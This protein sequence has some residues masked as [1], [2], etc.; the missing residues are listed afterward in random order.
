MVMNRL[1]AVPML[2]AWFTA[3]APTA[4]V[5]PLDSRLALPEE[6]MDNEPSDEMVIPPVPLCSVLAEVEAV[7]PRVRVFAPVPP[8]ATLTARAPV[9]VDPAML[10]VPVE[11]ASLP[12][13]I[14]PE[15]PMIEIAEVLVALPKLIVRLP[16]VP[17]LIVPAAAPVPMLIARVA[18]PLPI[19]IVP[20]PLSAPRLITPAVALVVIAIPPEPALSVN[21]DVFVALPRVIVRFVA[22]VPMDMAP[23]PPAEPMLIVPEVVASKVMACELDVAENAPTTAVAPVMLMP[24]PPQMFVVEPEAVFPMLTVRTKVRAPSEAEPRLI[25]SLLG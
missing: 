16:A 25:V 17:M 18:V 3:F 8:V 10:M 6:L 23:V 5:P 2:M 14:A 9:A 20:V 12:M 4:I 13:L 22:A 21:T 1:P 24:L 15:P 11:D 19:E 7:E